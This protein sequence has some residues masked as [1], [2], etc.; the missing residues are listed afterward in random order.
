[1]ARLRLHCAGKIIY[2]SSGIEIWLLAWTSTPL[3]GEGPLSSVCFDVRRGARVGP[4]ARFAVVLCIAILDGQVRT[5]WRC[6]APA[7]PL[8]GT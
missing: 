3:Q 4:A 5:R 8:L 6:S 2:R 1:M 7:L